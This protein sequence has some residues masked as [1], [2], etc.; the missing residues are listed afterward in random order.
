MVRHPILLVALGMLAEPS[1]FSQQAIEELDSLSHGLY[2]Q[3]PQGWK[4]LELVAQ[5]GTIIK[6]RFGAFSY[7]GSEAP[8]QLENRRPVFGIKLEASRPDI[9]GG[10]VR[11]LIIVHM[12]KKKDHRELQFVHGA[13]LVGARSGIDSAEVAD[14]TLT[15][16]AER[17]YTL[18]PKA[19]L[20]PGEYLICFRG[21]NGNAG[22][23]FGVR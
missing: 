2:Y 4:K 11:D 20:K 8:T 23:D 5:S 15:T 18:I 10:N 6:A 22:Y 16:V 12:S 7:I 1:A 21:T 19:D 13:G 14:T 3:A 17:T 9:P